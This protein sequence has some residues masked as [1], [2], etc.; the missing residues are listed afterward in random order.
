[1]HGKSF[2]YEERIFSCSIEQAPLFYDFV[3]QLCLPR[4]RLNSSSI[5]TRVFAAIYIISYFSL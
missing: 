1:M 5:S 4:M 2:S 3:P